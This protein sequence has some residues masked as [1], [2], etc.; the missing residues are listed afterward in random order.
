MKKS[1]HITQL[2]YTRYHHPVSDTNSNILLFSVGLLL[3][4]SLSHSQNNTSMK[5]RSSELGVLY[6]HSYID[7]LADIFHVSLVLVPMKKHDHRTQLHYT[8]Y[9]HRVSNRAVSNDV[10]N[11]PLEVKQLLKG[12]CDW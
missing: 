10:T 7:F 9:H 1:D 5:C 6:H 12:S 3:P 4:L 8:R 11:R 2:H